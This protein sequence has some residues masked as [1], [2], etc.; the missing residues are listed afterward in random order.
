MSCLTSLQSTGFENSKHL[1]LLFLPNTEFNLNKDILSHN[2]VP[3]EKPKYTP[4]GTCTPVWER[5]LYTNGLIYGR[6]FF[7]TD[8]DFCNIVKHQ[9]R[10]THAVIETTIFRVGLQSVNPSIELSCSLLRETTLVWLLQVYLPNLT[11]SGGS[12]VR[13]SSEHRLFTL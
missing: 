2:N 1:S 4:R 9:K 11:G 7:C 3:L 8:T 6:I 12:M 13:S 10:L 5:L